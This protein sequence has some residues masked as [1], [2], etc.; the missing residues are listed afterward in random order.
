LSTGESSSVQKRVC[1]LT[2]ASGRL[3][4]AFAARYAASYDIAAVHSTTPLSVPSQ[5]QEF[6]DPLNTDGWLPENDHRVFALRADVTDDAALAQVVKATIDRFQHIDLV[7]NAAV[8]RQFGRVT[9]PGDNL[10]DWAAYQMQVN[11]VVPLK[12]CRLV[13]LE[14]WTSDVASNRS[15]NRGVINISSTAGS[16]VYDPR[17]VVYAASKAALEHVTRHLAVEFAALGIRVNALAPNTFPG[18]VA[19][20]DVVDALVRLDNSEMTGEVVVVDIQDDDDTP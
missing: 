6:V 20:E 17:Q 1:L 5:D 14:C 11:V 15:A 18:I 8:F 7:V 13:A 4:T 10:V 16:N 19:T 3:G 9:D 12:L 2:G